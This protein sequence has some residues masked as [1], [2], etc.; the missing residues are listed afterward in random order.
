MLLRRLATH[1][2]GGVDRGA[3]FV[4]EL[5]RSRDLA[6]EAMPRRGVLDG[7]HVRRRATGE[8]ER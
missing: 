4:R 2:A 1:G 6:R 7:L 8:R 5:L 3:L